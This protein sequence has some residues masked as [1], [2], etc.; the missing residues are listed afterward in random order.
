MTERPGN[1][2]D[3]YPALRRPSEASR[4]AHERVRKLLAEARQQLAIAEPEARGL[5]EPQ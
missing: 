3:E 2:P 4:H 1:Q 5:L